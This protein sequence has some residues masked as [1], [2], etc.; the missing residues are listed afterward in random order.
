[1]KT[2]IAIIAISALIGGMALPVEAAPKPTVVKNTKSSLPAIWQ[3]VSPSQRLQMVRAAELDATRIL[4]ERIMGITLEGSTTVRDLVST[5]DAI[6][7]QL[8]VTL[9]GVKTTEGPIY[10]ED[11]RVEVVRAVKLKNLVETISKSS[12]SSVTKRTLRT[13]V[14]EIDALGNSAVPQSD[15]HARIRAKRAAEMDVYRRL[16][17]RVCGLNLTSSSSVKD[18]AL[19]NDE[20][21]ACLSNTIKS[22]EITAITYD[23][24][25][26]AAV[27]ASLAIGPLIRVIEKTVAANG[28]V[29]DKKETSRQ[30][31]IEET[32]NGAATATP[33]SSANATASSPTTKEVDVMIDDIISSSL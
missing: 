22:A 8:A 32:G 6:K 19:E 14:T 4:A 33:T 10:H 15:G 28:T 20:I 24:E 1:M 27:T 9:K 29:I 23:E 17:E 3:S 25:N 2:T 12:T 7:G 16:A 26:S 18:F 30:D 13:V 5:S 21:R 31:T 11:G